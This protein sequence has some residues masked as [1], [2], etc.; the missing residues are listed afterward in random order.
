MAD[1]ADE[2]FDWME[3][4]LE[5]YSGFWVL[6]SNRRIKVDYAR[7]CTLCGTDGVT[8]CSK[9]DFEEYLQ[10]KDKVAAEALAK[11]NQLAGAFKKLYSIEEYVQW[12]ME[13]LGVEISEK[14]TW[15]MGHNDERIDTSQAEFTELAYLGIPRY[16]RSI[17]EDSNGNLACPPLTEKDKGHITAAI[18]ELLA[19]RA[20]SKIKRIRKKL[21][22]DPQSDFPIDDWCEELLKAYGLKTHIEE[23]VCVFKHMLWSIKRAIWLKDVDLP[24]FYTFYSK[25]QKIGKTRLIQQ[26]A[27]SFPDMYSGSGNLVSLTDSKN[28]QALVK[29]RALIDFQ[30]LAIGGGSTK[31]NHDMIA[32]LKQAIT[33]D[34]I[35]GRGLYT[36]SDVAQQNRAVMCSSTN[37]HVWDIVRDSTGMRRY[38]EF[39]LDP[40]SPTPYR[41][42][43]ELLKFITEAYRAIDEED[44]KGFFHDKAPLMDKISAI[45]EGYVKM[46]DKISMFLR[47]S[48]WTVGVGEED[49]GPQMAADGYECMKLRSFVSSF[50]NWLKENKES[51]NYWTTSRVR[52]ALESN[53]FYTFDKENLK[54]GS[55]SYLWVKR[56]TK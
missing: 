5:K 14:K 4:N 55:E 38:F 23:S 19:K 53:N 16:N 7:F 15:T 31:V 2:T 8:P 49:D 27:E 17:P 10:E 45:Q 42:A 20:Q 13:E 29:G 28:A 41:D 37:I 51:D 35:V 1:M 44:D 12:K 9:T 6:K 18:T 24:L 52:L 54:G 48:G 22:F 34:V 56:R 11:K 43:E 30:E 36:S 3:S 46:E 47:N 39:L 33:T 21:A 32:A 40:D 25:K 26:L 50:A